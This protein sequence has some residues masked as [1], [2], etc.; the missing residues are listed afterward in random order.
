[1][2]PESPHVHTISWKSITRIITAGLLLVAAYY[3]R[4]LLLVLAAA[5]VLSSFIKTFVERCAKWRINRTF[6]VVLFFFIVFFILSAIFYLFVPVFVSELS[7]LGPEL[8]KYLPSSEA[9][10][11]LESATAG[12]QGI[13]SSFFSGSVLSDLE[14]TIKILVSSS[15]GGFFQAL[16][17]TFGGLTNLVLVVVLSFFLSV[18]PKT[19]EEFLRTIV[20]PKQEDYIVSLWERTERKIGLWFQGQL[21]LAIIVGTLTFLGLSIF[22]VKYALVLALLTALLELVPFGMV[23][24]TIPALF[25]SYLDGGFTLSIIVAGFYLIVHQFESYLIA[26]LI[27]KKVVGV[28]PLV[29]I[30]SLIIGVTLAGFWGIVLAVPVAVFVLEYARDVQK[31]KALK[32]T[33]Q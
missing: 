23:L 4:D 25:F 15:T 29:V 24:A 12:A 26:P 20:S 10:K 17:V 7:S 6:A 27:V 28:S 13:L 9:I 33:A 3:L 18:A 5:I 1:M 14:E 8:G 11:S 22:G 31:H 30:L 2:Q 21:L 32:K 16:Y 19:I